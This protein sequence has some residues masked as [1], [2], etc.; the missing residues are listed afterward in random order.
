MKLLDLFYS[1]PKPKKLESFSGKGTVLISFVRGITNIAARMSPEEMLKLLHKYLKIQTA[2]IEKYS[3]VVLIT[4]GDSIIAFW[5]DS[6]NQSNSA[7][8]AFQAAQTMLSN[9][10]TSFGFQI[11]LGTGDMAGDYFGP[12]K[13]FQVVGEAMNIADQLSQFH[14]LVSVP[15]REILLTE[16][17]RSQFQSFSIVASNIGSLPN[18]VQVFSYAAG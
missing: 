2:I 15:N 14:R 11:V 18:N 1:K 16:K 5:N 8:L 6:D 17:T 9:V 4:V 3:G 12:I 10:E 7:E 13:Q